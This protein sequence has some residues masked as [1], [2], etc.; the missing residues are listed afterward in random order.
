MSL[1]RSQKKCRIFVVAHLVV[2][3]QRL[4][5]K[6]LL[7]SRFGHWPTTVASEGEWHPAAES[8]ALGGHSELTE[9]AFLG[10][11]SDEED[12]VQNFLRAFVS[13]TALFLVHCRFGRWA[14]RCGSMSPWG[15]TGTNTMHETSP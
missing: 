3:P 1:S 15:H 14:Q 8:V 2:I 13:V 5:P 9:P 6:S 12:G 10:L 4:L 11:L 7:S